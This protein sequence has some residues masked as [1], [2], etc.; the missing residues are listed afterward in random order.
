[1]FSRKREDAQVFVSNWIKYFGPAALLDSRNEKH[2]PLFLEAGKDGITE[3]VERWS[4]VI[5]TWK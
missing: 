5:E 3:K 2:L 1:M 4:R